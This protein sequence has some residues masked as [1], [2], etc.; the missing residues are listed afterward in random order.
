[1]TSNR[2]EDSGD[3]DGSKAREPELD[4]GAVFRWRRCSCHT[5][6]S[7]APPRWSGTALMRRWCCAG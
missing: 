3:E 6:G 2:N 7:T 1:V 4:E 5:S